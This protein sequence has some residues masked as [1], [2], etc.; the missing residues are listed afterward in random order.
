MLGC[1][2]D[3]VILQATFTG[4]RQRSALSS[5]KRGGESDPLAFAAVNTT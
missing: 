4:R 1:V 2:E 5:K 3:I